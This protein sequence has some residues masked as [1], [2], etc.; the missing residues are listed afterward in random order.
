MSAYHP[1]A[2]EKYYE[3]KERDNRP[4]STV[5]DVRYCVVVWWRCPE[6]PRRARVHECYA[7]CCI[8]G[9]EIRQDQSGSAAKSAFDGYRRRPRRAAAALPSWANARIA[10]LALGQSFRGRRRKKPRRLT[11]F[12]RMPD[13]IS[14][15]GAFDSN[16]QFNGTSVTL[17]LYFSWRFAGSKS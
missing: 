6:T 8:N 12:R 11:A 17:K 15:D 7:I 14:I 3:D 4:N 16:S 1:F 10:Y 2:L 9:T 5:S 13:N